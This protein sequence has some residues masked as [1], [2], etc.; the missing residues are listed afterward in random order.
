MQSV[1][2]SLAGRTAVLKLLPFSHKELYEG[3]ILS[4]PVEEEILFG[5]Y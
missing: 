4:L 3:N 2:Q 5:S 1:T